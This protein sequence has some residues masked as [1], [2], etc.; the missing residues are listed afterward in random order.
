MAMALSPEEQKRLIVSPATDAGRPA[1][2]AATRAMLWPC[3]PCGWPQPRITSSTSFLSS[4]GTL[5]SAS[6]MQWAARSDG[7]VM[8]NEPR[9][10]LASGVRLL[11]TTTASLMAVPFVRRV[12][13]A[14]SVPLVG[15]LTQEL[16]QRPE[17]AEFVVRL[18]DVGGQRQA[19]AVDPGNR[20]AERL[21]ADHVGALGLAAVEQPGR[22]RLAVTQEEAEERAVGLVAPR[23]LGRAD[24]VEAPAELGHREQVIVDV[25]HE[26]ETGTTAQAVQ[27]LVDVVEPRE[28]R[29]GV[30][31]V[32]DEIGIAA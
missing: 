29:E 2:I 3:E 25:R 24:D 28:P 26:R 4:C 20:D 31:V 19:A 8:L 21:G 1:R 16:R 30:E 5:P 9:A 6:L 27:C 15:S 12:R 23:A 17:I 32:A 13:R 7:S 11:A 18:G 10:D 22:V 14:A